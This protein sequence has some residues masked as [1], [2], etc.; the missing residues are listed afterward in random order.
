VFITDQ[1][2]KPMQST[3]YKQDKP[4]TLSRR[5]IHQQVTD[6]IIQQL[7][8]G[9]IPWHQPWVTYRNGDPGTPI[10]FKI[11]HNFTTGNKYRGINI[12]LLWNAAVNN[13]FTTSEWASY[14]Q[15][16]DK[17]EQVKGGEKGTMIVY[18]DTFEKEVD[19]EIEKI[20]FIKSSFV[21]NR[22][23]LASYQ[24]EEQPTHSV[25]KP[26]F[27]RITRVEEFV[28]NTKAIIQHKE[29][30]AYYS[31]AFDHINMPEP[32]LFIATATRTAKEAYY[33]TLLHELTHW[34]GSPTRLNRIKGK[35]FGD[36]NYAAEELA[37]ELGACFLSA[38]LEIEP[39]IKGDHASYID[40]WLGVLKKDKHCIFTAASEASKAVDYLQTLQPNPALRG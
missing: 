31:R 15:W 7:Q 2:Q 11:P 28:S 21:F 12:V 33:S 8:A 10:P 26:A 3:A 19:G 22:S 4:S 23:Q 29:P 40:H 38:E 16:Q 34:S 18:Y 27:E 13:G 9:T 6:T 24:P 17:K 36:Q 32:E 1:E 25:I 5:D 37:A 39:T 35:R 14:K 20:P 30:E